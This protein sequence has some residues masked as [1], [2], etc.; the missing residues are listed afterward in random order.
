[1]DQKER[2]KMLNEIRKWEREIAANPRGSLVP[3]M[4]HRIAWLQTRLAKEDVRNSEQN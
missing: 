4:Q 2:A 3:A 1:V